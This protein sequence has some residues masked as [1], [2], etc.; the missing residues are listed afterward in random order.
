MAK[1][2]EILLN[3]IPYGIGGLEEVNTD[4]IA[5][6]AV[7]P[8]QTSFFA[9]TPNIHVVNVYDQYATNWSY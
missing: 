6:K 1:F 8:E 3:N 2:D 5:D 7:T 4:N 9:E